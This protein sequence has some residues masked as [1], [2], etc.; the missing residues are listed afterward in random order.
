MYWESSDVVLHGRGNGVNNGNVHEC[1]RN[2][3]NLNRQSEK[4]DCHCLAQ[5]LEKDY[6]NRQRIRIVWWF[7]RALWMH[8]LARNFT[9]NTGESKRWWVQLIPFWG[10]HLH[11]SRSQ[12]YD[13]YN[14]VM[15]PKQLVMSG[16]GGGMMCYL[17]Y[18]VFKMFGYWSQY[19]LSNIDYIRQYITKFYLYITIFKPLYLLICNLIS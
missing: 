11:D 13:V 8:D 4:I 9:Y 10:S 7:L 19:L 18:K 3:R 1:S 12:R 2:A 15:T 16:M 14:L 6:G 17:F 5:R